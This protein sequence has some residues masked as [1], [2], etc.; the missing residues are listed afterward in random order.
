MQ[1]SCDLQKA[2]CCVEAQQFTF[3]LYLYIYYTS[4]QITFLIITFCLN[5]HL[6]TSI[7]GAE[8]CNMYNMPTIHTALKL[9]AP[10]QAWTVGFLLLNKKYLEHLFIPTQF[11]LL[12]TIYAIKSIVGPHSVFIIVSP[13]PGYS[14]HTSTFSRGHF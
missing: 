9:H 10:Y 11:Y 7:R 8:R 5:P 13:L 14:L 6:P 4:I 12:G 3:L 2:L 1:K